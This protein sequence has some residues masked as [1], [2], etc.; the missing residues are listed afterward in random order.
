[1]PLSSTKKAEI[2]QNLRHWFNTTDE[3]LAEP[4][5]SLEFSEQVK[6]DVNEIYTRG[7]HK[8]VDCWG[9]RCG[10]ARVENGFTY[11][12]IGELIGVHHKSIQEQEKKGKPAE[13][14]SFYLEAFSLIY[15][16]SPYTLLGIP[17][18]HLLCP[19]VSKSNQNSKYCNVIINSLYDENDSNKLAHLESLTKIGKI[20]LPQ[21]TKLLS[22]LRDLVIFG[23]T[24]NIN[25]L[26]HSTAESDCW[27][28]IPIPPLLDA[29]QYGSNLYHQRRIFWEAR[30][31]LN[32]LEKHNP[33]RLHVLAQLA[34]CQPDAANILKSIVIDAGFPKD[35]KSVKKYNVDS[36]LIHTGKKKEHLRKTRPY[37]AASSL[38]KTEK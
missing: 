35:P 12:E 3:Q 32:D 14:D 29:D 21:Y 33:A 31:V 15:H 5:R 1:M 19:F 2:L 34:L 13:D 36:I 27:H 26:E 23:D 11:D 10:I 37:D 6:S 16:Q 30:Y 18:P 28:K 4:G 24:F 9:Y 7:L 8:D 17:S 25:P 20:A 22:F 38:Y